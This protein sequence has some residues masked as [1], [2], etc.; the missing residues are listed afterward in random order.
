MYGKTGPELDSDTLHKRL[1]YQAALFSSRT[2]S[3]ICSV[4]FCPNI[5]LSQGLGEALSVVGGYV[6]PVSASRWKPAQPYSV[7]LKT[8]RWCL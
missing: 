8:N 6:G 3:V 5:R 2:S 7:L 1:L 4:L